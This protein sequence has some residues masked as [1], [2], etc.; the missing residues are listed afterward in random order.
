MSDESSNTLNTSLLII[1]STFPRIGKG[2]ELMWG[3]K[4]FPKYMGKLIADGR[5]DRQGFPFEVL[6][7]LMKLQLLHDKVYPEFSEKEDDETGF[8]SSIFE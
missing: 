5:F 1:H 7:A 4:G 2:I 6:E 3:D 8:G